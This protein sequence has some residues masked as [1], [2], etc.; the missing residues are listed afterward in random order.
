MIELSIMAKLI[1]MSLGFFIVGSFFYAGKYAAGYKNVTEG[2]PA[3]LANL[4]N[5]FYLTL[6]ICVIL[7]WV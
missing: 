4:F 7:G 2:T 5:A 3:V 6:I 1:I